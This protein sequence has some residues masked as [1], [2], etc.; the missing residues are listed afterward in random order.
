MRQGCRYQR[1]QV[2][3]ATGTR[4]QYSLV[5]PTLQVV[6]GLQA[7]QGVVKTVVSQALHERVFESLTFS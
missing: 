6:F 3:G 7:T 2:P 4:G 5:H 1:P